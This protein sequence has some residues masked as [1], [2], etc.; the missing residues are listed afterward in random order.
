MNIVV[1]DLSLG[2]LHR[3]AEYDLKTYLLLPLQCMSTRYSLINYTL[4]F[5]ILWASSISGHRP[6]EDFKALY[7]HQSSQYPCKT[8]IGTPILLLSS[9]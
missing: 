8:G 5:A 7:K 6:S 4:L 1:T 2:N 3:V 9:D